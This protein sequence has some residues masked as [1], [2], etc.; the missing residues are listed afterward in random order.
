[1]KK[2]FTFL[3][4][5]YLSVIYCQHDFDIEDK[6]NFIDIALKDL[7]E[8]YKEITADCDDTF[9]ASI[10]FGVLFTN[11][12]DFEKD[13]NDIRNFF[14]PNVIDY[15]TNNETEKGLIDEDN[16]FDNIKQKVVIYK[17]QD[18]DSDKWSFLIIEAN[19]TNLIS[20]DL[21][22]PFVIAV[23]SMFENMDFDLND[24]VNN[25][26]KIVSFKFN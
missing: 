8:K 5:F 21:K 23:N 19:F 6:I 16:T 26:Y 13:L 20:D 14:S 18:P 4:V 10:S 3:F 2:I 12:D 25:N 7:T 17:N 15:L 1:M 22:C 24:L 11:P 9:S